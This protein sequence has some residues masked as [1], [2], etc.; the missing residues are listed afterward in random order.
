MSAVLVAVFTDHSIANAVRS[1]LVSDGFPTDRVDLTSREELGQAKLVPR[2]SVS[3]QLEAYFRKVF[4]IDEGGNQRSVDFVRR[5]VLEGRAVLIV[6][7]RG[8]VEN[9]RALQL[10]SR[11]DPLDVQGT[12]LDNTT[13]E[14]AATD[15]KA[16]TIT[17]VGKALAA[18]GARDTTGTPKLP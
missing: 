2:D 4:Q 16:S 5:A 14:Q 8:E 15:K 9:E 1:E 10:L 18:G 7:P 13:M 12:D 17:W 11:G 6:Q 3:E